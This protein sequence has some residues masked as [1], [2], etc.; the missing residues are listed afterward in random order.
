MNNPTIFK[1]F[2]IGQIVG[3]LTSTIIMLSI[4]IPIVPSVPHI[5]TYVGCLINIPIAIQN[6]V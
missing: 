2:A 5:L 4:G 1:F 3:T 6:K